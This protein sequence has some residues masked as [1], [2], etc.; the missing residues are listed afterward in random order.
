MTHYSMP[1]P[2]T[3]I[4]LLYLVTYYLLYLYLLLSELKI[5]NNKCLHRN[6]AK[7]SNKIECYSGKKKLLK[8]L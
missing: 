3:E 5:S 4:Y 2:M 6:N 7:M 1:N 8:W